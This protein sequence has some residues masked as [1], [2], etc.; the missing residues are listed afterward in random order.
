[1][2][3]PD[4]VQYIVLPDWHTL[5]PYAEGLTFHLLYE[6]HRQD[7]TVSMQLYQIEV[8]QPTRALSGN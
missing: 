4:R 5:E 8:S 6:A 1:V 7:G 3:T 2:R